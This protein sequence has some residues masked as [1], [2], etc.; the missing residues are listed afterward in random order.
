LGEGT[1]DMSGYSVSIN[2]AG[3]IV[4]IGAILNDGQLNDGQLNDGIN[5]N[6][7]GNTRIFK[8]NTISLLWEQLDQDIDGE[9]AGD[10]SG[11][12]VS[13]SLSGYT[14]AIGS[15]LN[16]NNAVFDSGST[17][18][19]SY[20]GLEWGRVGQDIDGERAGEKSGYSVALSANGNILAV[21][22]A[23]ESSP[24]TRIY[25]YNGSQWVK[26]CQD[27]SN[28]RDIT[29]S[30]SLSSD[31]SIIA[32]GTNVYKLI[33]NKYADWKI[34]SY[35]EAG[36][37]S[38]EGSEVIKNNFS[39][40]NIQTLG[41]Y[42]INYSSTDEAKN[43]ATNTRKVTV[44]E[45]PKIN[46]VKDYNYLALG[47]DLTL[48]NTD[49]NSTISYSASPQYNKN[50][51]G[52]YSVTFSA[53]SN[54]LFSDYSIPVFNK[55]NLGDYKLSFM[56][57]NTT[58][59]S[60]KS[61]LTKNITVAV[62][63]TLTLLGANPYNL[64][65]G[66]EY[67]EP[68]WIKSSDTN[69]IGSGKVL[70]EVQGSYEIIYKV[71]FNIPTVDAYFKRVVIVKK[72]ISSAEKISKSNDLADFEAKY[73]SA[74]IPAQKESASKLTLYNDAKAEV[75]LSENKIKTLI[76]VKELYDEYIIYSS[77]LNSLKINLNNY[78]T[79]LEYE[80]TKSESKSDIETK[81][82]S[83]RLELAQLDLKILES[84]NIADKYN[85]E[86]TRNAV[87]KSLAVNNFIPT[88][89]LIKD[90]YYAINSDYNNNE[91][92][93]ILEKRN[94]FR[95]NALSYKTSIN[96]YYNAE[97]TSISIASLED[98]NLKDIEY[99]KQ[100][101]N[102]NI[103]TLLD[104]HQRLL[105][106]KNSAFEYSKL[107]NIELIAQKDAYYDPYILSVTEGKIN[108]IDGLKDYLTIIESESLNNYNLINTNK[109][110]ELELLKNNTQILKNSYDEKLS[111]LNSYVKYL[112]KDFIT[113]IV[114]NRLDYL[115]RLKSYYI[116]I[117]DYRSN[118]RLLNPV[119]D[120]I[121]AKKIIEL[122]EESLRIKDLLHMTYIDYFNRNKNLEKSRA[123]E[124]SKADYEIFRTSPILLS[125]L[126]SKIDAYNIIKS[127]INIAYDSL[128]YNISTNAISVVLSEKIAFLFELTKNA[129]IV[130]LSFLTL[131]ESNI[132]EAEVHLKAAQY[133]LLVSTSQNLTEI[134]IEDNNRI[135]E[136][137][138]YL[139]NILTIKF[140]LRDIGKAQI[141]IEKAYLQEFTALYEALKVEN[142]QNAAEVKQLLDEAKI[143]KTN[144]TNAFNGVD[145][146]LKFTDNT[147]T[148]LSSLKSLYD[149]IKNYKTKIN[150]QTATA[151][152]AANNVINLASVRTLKITRAADVIFYTK[153]ILLEP[154]Q[155]Q[156]SYFETLKLNITN[157][158]TF[159][160]ANKTNISVILKNAI[161]DLYNLADSA[162]DEAASILESLSEA[163]TEAA[164]YSLVTQV[165]LNLSN[166]YILSE[167][168][169][170]ADGIKISEA[171]AHETIIDNLQSQLANIYIDQE[172]S[173]NSYFNLYNGI[174]NSINTP[175]SIFGNT[176]KETPKYKNSL[177]SI[178]NSLYS[179]TGTNVT[180]VDDLE[181][182]NSLN[183][184]ITSLFNQ[185]EESLL[186]Q[187]NLS[188][189]I[190]ETYLPAL[191]AAEEEYKTV[192]TNNLVLLAEQERLLLAGDA[193]IDS[194]EL[195]TNT[196]RT[197]NEAAAAE[198]AAAA[199]AA[200]AATAADAAAAEAAAEA[201]VNAA[202]QL[203]TDSINAVN[204]QATDYGI[205]LAGYLA[206]SAVNLQN[207]NSSY[208][209]AN[210]AY[211]ESK[212]YSDS[213]ITS[214]SNALEYESKTLT[215]SIESEKI[216]SIT[217]NDINIQYNTEI[218]NLVNSTKAASLASATASYNSVL[219]SNISKSAADN[220]KIALDY[221]IESNN[222]LLEY[223]NLFDE[224][225]LALQQST[226]INNKTIFLDSINR[227]LDLAK[228]EYL[229][230]NIALND[231]AA[232]S[233]IAI[234]ANENSKDFYEKA[235]DYSIDVQRDKNKAEV[236]I[237]KMG[238]GIIYSAAQNYYAASE[239][240][241]NIGRDAVTTISDYV[242]SNIYQIVWKMDLNEALNSVNIKPPYPVD[243]KEQIHKK[244]VLTNGFIYIVG[245][246]ANTAEI[247][248]VSAENNYGGQLTYTNFNK[249]IKSDSITG[250]LE[251][252]LA[253]LA[254]YLRVLED[255]SIDILNSSNP[256]YIS[257]ITKKIVSASHTYMAD[258]LE[259]GKGALKNTKGY[260]S[261]AQDNAISTFMSNLKANNFWYS[262][263]ASN[264][265]PMQNIV[266]V[267]LCNL[268]DK[269][270]KLN[271]LLGSSASSSV[272]I[273]ADKIMR[274]MKNPADDFYIKFFSE[275][276]LREVLDAVNDKNSRVEYDDNNNKIF[277][278]I[279]GDSISAVLR[280][281]DGDTKETNSDRW[282]ITLLQ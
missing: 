195:I 230:S 87:E 1:D 47:S 246:D 211:L 81:I 75:I 4:A 105:A 243:E 90:E 85:T 167:E 169:K 231:A 56:P 109:D 45:I 133:K 52:S 151:E 88:Y 24:S 189:V 73:Q 103:S 277:N 33:N 241:I 156:I 89:D 14:V 275:Q 262:S 233:G 131:M 222:K 258:S 104:D 65:I 111:L 101:S 120:E 108:E 26:L 181:D 67:N 86:L 159:I 32:V 144:A 91:Y 54:N 60:I 57:K 279:E 248:I 269:E 207:S 76:S 10:E 132:Y 55:N 16:D 114:N 219:S 29:P 268:F 7:C 172:N 139:S 214:A 226:D 19:Y 223:K 36:A 99:E 206:T 43:V 256:I 242:P 255:R 272:F 250:S 270:R 129:S 171:V 235:R 94:N 49:L 177:F 128:K 232:A 107:L 30:I 225:L 205:E 70:Y 182:L 259:E 154:L 66:T 245:T 119:N 145:R 176:A 40:D 149:L 224:Q 192:N 216:A 11:F 115:N 41:E 141:A 240:L 51:T 116:A 186:L 217:P 274:K 280:I 124:I 134:I 263:N 106:Y 64:T 35:V 78:I 251:S 227:T 278:F 6:N 257:T 125:E 110:N 42:T 113:T 8:Y 252:R 72:E 247:E 236:I 138:D 197:A 201:A 173:Q 95:E 166:A 152:D 71:S 61:L 164:N 204:A 146:A 136:A 200:A 158:I 188:T 153:P 185:Y 121:I 163:K 218:I 53:T 140:Q 184:T 249:I 170:T 100:V 96:N 80:L 77:K 98:L 282:L 17:R 273:D 117:I 239:E 5:K 18:V 20:N 264:N 180:V 157:K 38:N 160:E 162:V 175:N 155:T 267:G 34:G 265:R 179:I 210:G 44:I 191:T 93:T 82:A 27:I 260:S 123:L 208:T 102:I 92:I 228:K 174:Y 58:N 28:G 25:A 127:K 142:T 69:V 178:R 221:V 220:T 148:Y 168:I 203:L 165:K 9:L 234:S 244:G 130:A 48:P 193:I 150:S 112:E 62:P 126:K 215:I 209:S 266:K 183:T 187:T 135:N 276:Q 190:A 3:N 143:N 74:L 196:V 21:A 59:T 83:K 281:V 79:A 194:T 46:F 254:R 13:L 50:L 202:A 37:I 118:L 2:A 261:A 199:A 212:N 97:L 12:S 22:N 137:N 253:D 31:G 237:L 198:A 63:P 147:A 23:N 213:G 271:D 84:S 161:T 238:S 39:S 229:V 68:G 15:V 122:K